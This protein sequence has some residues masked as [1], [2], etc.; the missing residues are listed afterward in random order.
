MGK[1]PELIS[2]N[3]LGQSKLKPT[4]G[5]TPVGRT[6]KAPKRVSLNPRQ[7]AN[8]N[9][10]RVLNPQY[11]QAAAEAA[12]QNQAI[13][14]YTTAAMQ[15]LGLLAPQIQS[16]YQHAADTQSGLVNAAAESLRIEIPQ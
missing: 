16:D 12:R 9:V 1:A 10:N 14:A 4:S 3:G 15:Q 6:P 11:A 7:Q 5:K 8:L 2:E 13:Q